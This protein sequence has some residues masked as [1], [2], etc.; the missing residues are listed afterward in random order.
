MKWDIE[1]KGVNF[2]N[3]IPDRMDLKP[4][5][6]P[7]EMW[8]SDCITSTFQDLKVGLMEKKTEAVADSTLTPLV[9]QALVD[10]YDR[11]IKL[12][13]QLVHNVTVTEVVK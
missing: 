3:L 13:D 6:H 5:D 8:A 9:R 12:V 4:H 1:I 2:G 7:L 10:A 11:Q